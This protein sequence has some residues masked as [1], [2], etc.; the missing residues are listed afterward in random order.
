MKL[1]VGRQGSY[2]CDQDR[3]LKFL[4]LFSNLSDHSGYEM[5]F[6]RDFVHA[7]VKPV[8]VSRGLLTE[9]ETEAKNSI[10]LTCLG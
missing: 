5:R 10:F 3:R 7:N 6:R 8:W 2:L 1:S 4:G 9:L